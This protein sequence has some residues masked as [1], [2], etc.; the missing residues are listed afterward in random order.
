MNIATLQKRKFHSLAFTG[1]WAELFGEP[2]R[3]FRAMLYGDSGCGKSTFA[4][5]FADYLAL[6]FGKV[7]YNSFEEGLNKTIQDR[8]N[9]VKPRSQRLF[10]G[11]RIPFENMVDRIKRCHYRV[12]FID[13]TQFMAFTYDQYKEL[14]ALF[15][16][17]S[18]VFVSQGKSKGK[19]D[20]A[21]KILFAVDC[22]LFFK[23]GIVESESRFLPKPASKQLFI[24]EAK[25]RAAKRSHGTG[26]L[27]TAEQ[28]ETQ[29]EEPLFNPKP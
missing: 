24:P 7:F 16:K 22:K 2:E 4:L 14:T 5:Q 12:V 19:T 15:P 27:F 29:S 3:N 8:A 17:K 18:F 11:D 25:K 13:S 10:V 1:D 28:L 21:D 9:F 20:G 26:S 6:K 23:D